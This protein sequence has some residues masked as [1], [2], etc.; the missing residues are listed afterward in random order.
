MARTGVGSATSKEIRE[1]LRGFYLRGP[2]PRFRSESDLARHLDISRSTIAGWFQKEPKVPDPGHLIR[3]AKLDRLS[4]TFLLIGVGPEVLDAAVPEKDL[5]PMLRANLRASLVARGVPA[6]WIDRLLP[7][8]REVMAEL[9]DRYVVRW[10]EYL[11][12]VGRGLS[13][14]RISG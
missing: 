1:R 14:I 7:S 12:A 4:P 8:G 3:M 10:Q 2:A 5:E 6:Q 11:R 9:V 13:R